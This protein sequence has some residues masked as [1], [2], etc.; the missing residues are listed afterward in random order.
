MIEGPRN[1]PEIDTYFETDQRS[2]AEPVAKEFG[3]EYFQANTY[4]ALDNG[5]VNLFLN[6][7]T[8][9]ILEIFTDSKTNQ[10]VYAE[11]LKST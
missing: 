8:P 1:Q 9:G 7:N 10:K 5:I 6:K 3:F 2:T 11:D 4:Q